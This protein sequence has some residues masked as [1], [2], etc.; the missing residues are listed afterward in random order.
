MMTTKQD[1]IN[2][3]SNDLAQANDVASSIER[4]LAREWREGKT[5]TIHYYMFEKYQNIVV[6]DE[7][8][9]L[10]CERLRQK[11]WTVEVKSNWID[12]KRFVISG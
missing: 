2:Y 1:L 8:E 3:Q 11:G 5:I 9:R 6:N 7:I 4:T 10:V 12:M